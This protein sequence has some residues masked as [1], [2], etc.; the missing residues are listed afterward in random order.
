ML[1]IWRGAEGRE[2]FI[3]LHTNHNQLVSFFL[4]CFQEEE[5]LPYEDRQ[6]SSEAQRRL[7]MGILCT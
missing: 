3:D 5:T 6:F 7:Y 4:V 2:G 1:Q